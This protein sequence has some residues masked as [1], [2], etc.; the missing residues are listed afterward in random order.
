M[1]AMEYDSWEEHQAAISSRFE[2]DFESKYEIGQRQHSGR[3]WRKSTF[4][5]LKEEAID[6][7]SYL[8]TLE[9]HLL[10]VKVLLSNAMADGDWALVGEAFNIL[11]E[12]NAEGRKEEDR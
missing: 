12:G 10:D 5:M 11:V 1:K 8:Y 9:D 7:I 6:F 2:K 3:L 4:P